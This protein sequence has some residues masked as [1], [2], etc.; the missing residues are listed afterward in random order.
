MPPGRDI[1]LVCT[2]SYRDT[3]YS[4]MQQFLTMTDHTMQYSNH[5]P[6][7]VYKAVQQS[8]T[9]QIQETVWY[10]STIAMPLHTKRYSKQLP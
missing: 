6:D 8:V 10:S 1:A 3:G 4:A 9:I 7:A 2:D 5:T